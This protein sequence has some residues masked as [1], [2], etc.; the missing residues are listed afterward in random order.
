MK[1]IEL[2]DYILLIIGFVLGYLSSYI[3]AKQTEK[4]KN[5][6]LEVVNRE[7]VVEKTE[8]CPFIIRDY[9]GN[10][11]ENI[12]LLSTR[13]WNKGNDRIL[14]SEISM[15]FPLTITID[16]SAK[17]MGSPQVIKP[18]REMDF[19]IKAVNT[20]TFVISFDCL[21][22]D[23]WIQLGFFVTGNPRATIKASGRVFGQKTEFDI[24]TDDSRASWSE[25]ILSLLVFVI[26]IASP[27]LLVGSLYWFFSEYTIKDLF[28]NDKEF[29]PLLNIMFGFGVIVPLVATF[30][31]GLQW[32]KRRAH[33]K[34]YPI[35][36]DFE[37]SQIES[38]RAFLLT[39]ITGRRYRKSMSVY[40]YGEMNPK[41]I[42]HMPPVIDDKDK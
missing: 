27:F 28:I 5:L 2:K 36:E 6:V 1:N 17:L 40:D 25:R 14:G 11:I 22:P 19:S 7:I 41:P 21:N 42:D 10:T 24:T 33:P 13:V 29:P 18:S 34:G 32:L 38:L 4:K 35:P 16:K 20:N 23:E 31:F 8:Q 39:A 37:P 15:K 26:V 3:V 12:Y 9:D 30:Y